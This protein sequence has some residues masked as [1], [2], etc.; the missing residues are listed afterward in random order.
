MAPQLSICML[1]YELPASLDEPAVSGQANNPFYLVRGLH[2]AGHDLTVASVPSNTRAVS[3]TRFR[4]GSEPPT[5]DVPDGRSRALPRYLLRILGMTRF[6]RGIARGRKFDVIHAQHPALTA[7]ALLARRSTDRLHDVPI[8]STGHGTSLPEADA[9]GFVSVRQSLR[10]ANSRLLLPIDRFAFDHS[11]AVISVSQFQCDELT[12]LYHVPPARMSVIYNG[13][14]RTRYR[15]EAPPAT[16]I[17]GLPQDASPL[18]LFVGRLAPKKGLQY[19]IRA[20][21]EILKAFPQAHC[22]VV[23]GTP[24]YDSYGAV[25]KGMIRDLDLSSHFTWIEDGVPEVDLPNVY[26]RAD[27]CVFPSENYESLPTVIFEA[28]ACGIPVVTTNRWGSPEA[29]GAKHPGLVPEADT[30]AIVRAVVSIFGD[31]AR[32]ADVRRQQ[33]ER[34]GQFELAATVAQHE[35]LYRAVARV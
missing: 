31:S 19:L 6:L 15:P 14:D 5:Y 20:F 28:M 1:T 25:L 33:F 17:P 21:P 22:L 27:I 30:D 9:D 35:A 2:A 10:V 18:I 12:R 11:D 16:D 34:I 29:L 24:A 3:S 7:A 8:V 32:Y 13:V 26:T 23:G 4:V